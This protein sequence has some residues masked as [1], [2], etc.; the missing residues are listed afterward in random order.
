MVREG[1]MPSHVVKAVAERKKTAD[2]TIST[3]YDNSVWEDE[4]EQ[5][6]TDQ[7]LGYPDFSNTTNIKTWELNL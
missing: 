1:T 4:T 3:K 5:Y 7:F 2:T 6:T